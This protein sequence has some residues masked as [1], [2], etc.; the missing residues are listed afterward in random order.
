MEQI[1][2]NG[3]QDV[4]RAANTISSAADVMNSAA[5]NIANS[6]YEHQK[7]LEDWLQ[8]LEALQEKSIEG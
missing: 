4:V 5:N 6:L 8:R 2:L 3:S 7:F 1:Y